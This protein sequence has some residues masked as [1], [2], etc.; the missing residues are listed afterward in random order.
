MSKSPWPSGRQHV[1]N[2]V[3]WIRANKDEF[4]ELQRLCLLVERATTDTGSYRYHRIT[5]GSIYMLAEMYGIKVGDHPLYKRD[6]SLWSTVSRYLTE[7]HPQLN[8]VIRH[9]DQTIIGQ[10][11]AIHGLPQLHHTYRYKAAVAA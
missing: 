1:D 11:V 2:A 3:S 8:R 6:K 4:K 7:Y 9:K 10:Y 5:C